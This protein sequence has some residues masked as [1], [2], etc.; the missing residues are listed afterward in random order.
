MDIIIFLIL[1]IIVLIVFRDSKVIIFF[2]GTSDVLLRLI[3]FIKDQLAIRDLTTFVNKYIPSSVV[4]IIQN[5]TSGIATTLLDWLYIFIM[6]A[7][8]YYLFRHML[9][10][11]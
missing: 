4:G 8:V 11:K 9:K 3:H 10:L 7:F 6:I 5:S 1:I 2:I